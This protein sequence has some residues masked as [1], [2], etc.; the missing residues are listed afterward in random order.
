MEMGRVTF[1][2]EEI[3][4][5]GAHVTGTELPAEQV[6]QILRSLIDSLQNKLTTSRVPAV[7]DYGYGA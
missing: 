5:P 1:E 2:Y 6:E 3:D 4:V 7:Y